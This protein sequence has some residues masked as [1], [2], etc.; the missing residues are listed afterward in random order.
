M[1][2]HLVFFLS[3]L[4]FLSGV[5]FASLG[6][7]FLFSLVPAAFLFAA[8]FYFE[9]SAKVAL[10]A[11]GL[12]AF[13]CLYYWH[14]DQ[15]YRSL[16]A[17]LPAKG[18]LRGTIINDP[19]QA[20]D[21]QSFYLKTG[22]GKILIR[23]G[24]EAKY[25]YGD[26]L[27]AAGR[28]EI[29]SADSYGLFLA[30]EKVVGVM[31]KPRIRL[32]TS[33]G[34]NKILAFLF[35][36]KEKIKRSFERLLPPDKAAFLF[37]VMMGENGD[38][39]KQFSQN[40]GLSGLRFLTAID[41]LHMTI[42]VFIIFGFLNYLLPRR[43]AFMAAFTIITLFVALTGFTASGVRAAVMAFVSGLAAQT[44]RQYAPRNALALVVLALTLQNPKVAVFDVGFQLS[45]LAVLSIIY[46][47]PVLAGLLR[48][49]NQPGFLG[50]KASLL[51][52]LSVQLAAAPVL[53][54]QFQNFSLTA[55]IAGV[56]VVVVLPYLLTLGFL[57]A[58]FSLVFYPLAQ[59]L[60]FFAA[61]LIAYVIFIINLFA[62]LAVPFNPKLG[63]IAI[64][65]YYGSL[66][67]LTFWFYGKK[68]RSAAVPVE[69][70]T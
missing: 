42:M 20:P 27:A 67:S 46:F 57:L 19:R 66:I 5:V 54:T 12:L 40:L 47:K 70:K 59:A 16:V 7:P 25:F 34:G 9:D 50:L 8:L 60:S 29:P 31:L 10:L 3:V 49:S 36:Q 62:R 61:P 4:A 33:G 52:A 32:L 65:A 43:Y 69:S 68:P 35:R 28:I 15:S 18:E 53:I 58:I 51:I 21:F 63:V 14:D 2:R 56:L 41:G 24:P 17:N 13:G 22:A 55:F 26:G 30:K 38:F 39:S 11:A 37:G 48:L 1:P 6:L 45:F 23:T 64:A 44:G